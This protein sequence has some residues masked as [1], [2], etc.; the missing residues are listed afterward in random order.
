MATSIPKLL[1][2][3]V[4]AHPEVAAQMGKNREGSF[5]SRSFQEL[6][7]EVQ[8]FAAGLHKLK[9]KRGDHVGLISE[10]R[11]EWFV[12]DLAILSLGAADVPRGNDSM[13]AELG[14][15]L[16]FSD[17]SLVIVENADQMEKVL[18][19]K[20][21]IPSLKRFVVLD[22][23]YEK[24][25]EHSVP[26]STYAEVVE[27][28][29]AFLSSKPDFVEKEILL[30][31][32]E[33]VATIIFTSGTTGEPK[34]VVLTHR[35]FLYQV[36][37]I[38]DRVDVSPGDIWLCVLPVWHSFERIVQYIAL[39]TASTLAY[40]KPIGQIMLADMAII[41]PKWMASVPRIWEAVRAGIYRNVKQNGGVKLIIFS[42]FVSVGG[43][44]K[45]LSDMIFGRTPQFRKRSQ[46]LDF[47][48][49]IVPYLLIMPL[50][51]LGNALVFNK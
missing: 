13:A 16:G 39:A 5:E 1:Q 4:S 7:V 37:C 43:F 9:V 40:S 36:D 45:K 49:A 32:E 44:H 24:K 48:V 38:P 17:C 8:N 46:V 21:E 51:F 42:F 50:K 27:T 34:G 29:V 33:D 28:G 2:E 10:N 47:L 22:P 30:G 26:V 15:I 14:Y 41:K 11:K 12:S 6:Y 20:K 25:S 35:N 18:S 3:I 31:G 23:G 19:V